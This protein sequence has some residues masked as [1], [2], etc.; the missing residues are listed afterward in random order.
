MSSAYMSLMQ[1]CQG[2]EVEYETQYYREK[3]APPLC[4]LVLWCVYT[5][6][7]K[8][9]ERHTFIIYIYA[10]NVSVCMYTCNIY[11]KYILHAASSGVIRSEIFKR[12]KRGFYMIIA[13]KQIQTT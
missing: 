10:F 4:Q 13:P 3:D 11:M 1:M 6:V 7:C 2:P 12:F 5:C 9:T 8:H